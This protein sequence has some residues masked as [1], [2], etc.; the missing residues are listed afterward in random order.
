MRALNKTPEQNEGG[1]G[2]NSELY[3]L[4]P[5]KCIEQNRAYHRAWHQQNRERVEVR[6]PDSLPQNIDRAKTRKQRWADKHKVETRIARR[7]QHA[8]TRIQIFM[9]LGGPKCALCG[10]SANQDALQIDHIRG[11]GHT[12]RAKHAGGNISAKLR[13]IKENPERFQVLCGNC[14]NIKSNQER[15]QTR[16]PL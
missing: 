2:K 7:N 4:D 10:Y 8:E 9:L 3:K 15:R 14:H 12:D 16:K 5:E 1:C 13:A 11:D 6:N